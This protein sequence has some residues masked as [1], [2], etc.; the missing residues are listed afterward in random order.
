MVERYTA[1]VFLSLSSLLLSACGE[2]PRSSDHDTETGTPQATARDE[3]NRTSGVGKQETAF[4]TVVR[5]HYPVGSH[6]IEL[7][8]DHAPLAWDKGTTLADANGDS[9]ELVLG[10]T[11]APIAFKPTLDGKPARGPNYVV[12][13]GQTLDIFPHFTI[14][15]GSVSIFQ[16]ELESK[17][18]GNKRAIRMYLPPSYEENTVARYPV[19]YMHDGQVLF[20]VNLTAGDLSA[21]AFSGSW[22]VD[23]TFDEGIEAG[24]LP[25]AIVIGVDNVDD[26]IH[27]LA[28]AETRNSELT[29]TN[30]ETQTQIKNSGRGPEYLKMITDEIKPLVD[31]KLRTRPGRE[32]TYMAGSSLGGLMSSWS[33]IERGDLFVGI[34]NL[35]GSNFWDHEIIIEKARN[36]K[37]GL[38]HADKVYADMG[39]KEGGDA[40]S[41]REAIRNEFKRLVS[42]YVEAGYVEGKTL[43]TVLDPTGKHHGDAWSKRFPAALAFLL[44]PGR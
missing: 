32:N 38:P 27:L 44:G 21:K 3:P 24:A 40:A 5:V 28:S 13:P 12:E 33:G 34:A 43:M 22:D 8:G 7:V 11:E 10:N 9:W 4:A 17:N 30:D 18:L 14:E 25:E 36:A 31:S 29:P 39:E 23:K 42:A 20:T 35:S 1:L 15:R 41:D 6:K 19:I 2:E 37:V 26:G 16:N